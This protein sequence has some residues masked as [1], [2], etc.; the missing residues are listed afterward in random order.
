MSAALRS[1]FT[2][3]ELVAEAWHRGKQ[4]KAILSPAQ[5]QIQL[6]YDAKK[7][8]TYVVECSRQL[9]K[10]YWACFLADK[11]ARA[12]PNCQIR[13]ATAFEVDIASIIVP[14]YKNVL[15]TCPESLH[16]KYARGRY[17]YPN[18]AQ[19]LFVGLDKN[20]NKLRGNRILLIII[21]EAGF[22]DSEK[23]QYVLDSVIAGAQLREKH[24]RTVLVSTPPEEGQDHYFCTV[25]DQCELAGSYIKI[26]IDESGLPPEAIEAFVKKLGGRHTVAFRREGMCERILDRSR[27]LCEEWDDK[28]V[29]A[30]EPDEFFQYYHKLTFQDLGRVDHTALL[31]GYY[32]FKR[33]ALVMTH[34]STMDGP[35][36]TTLTLK[37][38][39]KSK[40][41][42]AFGEFKVFRRISDNNNPHLLQDLGS[43]HNVHFMP[44][45]KESSL[46]QMVNRVREWVK[47]GRVLIHPRCKMLIGCMKY[48]VWDKKRKEFAQSK[49]Y[50]HYDHFAALMYG[51]IHT[52]VAS[53]PIPAD[54]GYQNHKAWLGN[55]KDKGK[56]KN[57]ETFKKV[58]GPK[59]SN[60]TSRVTRVRHGR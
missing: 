35:E 18:G 11:V 52:P 6:V 31:Y 36:W 41:Q 16:P 45:T 47:S 26:T 19:V 40:E 8:P 38:E 14:N 1:K 22:V 30:I 10:T 5:K 60:T 48:G 2:R 50:G 59:Q 46:E 23:L 57:A 33:A 56:S 9:G 21:E 51:I 58:F 53:N 44:V 27:A 32:D 39:V 4:E 49:V 17:T 7:D 25:A 13:L 42:E 15:A 3:E 34:E 24:A 37:D 29:Q 43:I 28:F 20:P 55:V 12:N 54:H